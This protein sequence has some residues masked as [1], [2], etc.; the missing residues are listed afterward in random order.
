MK[1]TELKN[2]ISENGGS[3]FLL[4]GEDAYFLSRAEDMIKKAYLQ[5]PELNYTSFDGDGLKGQA[6]QR[7]TDAL[8][9]FPFMAEKRVIKVSEFYPSESDY[10][11]YLK[12]FFAAFPQT[13]VLIIVNIG[14]K[15]GAADLKRKAGVAYVDCG[16]AD[17]EEVTRWIYLTLKRAFIVANAEV[18]MNIARYCLCNM[19][20]VSIEVQKIKEYMPDGGTLTQEEADNLVFKDADYRIYEMTNAVAAGNY[21]LFYEIA[22]ELADKG[23]DGM[24]VL[25]SLFSY[26]R[27]LTAIAS[28][29][30]TDAELASIYGMKEYGV[31]RTREQARRLGTDRAQSLCTVIY[32]AI[33]GVKCGELTPDSAYRL[34][35]S[36][37]FFA[38]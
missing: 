22:E 12:P 4:Q 1:F 8:S 2:Y 20:R 9:A 13:A 19:S 30:K 11:K 28:S 33:S 26:M 25:N 38:R 31:K 14:T 3:I 36:Q 21:S 17:E 24:S 16:K 29:R 32:G 34:V 27:N 23:M 6:I 18:C 37:I 5:M 7:L 15:K 10:E 35:C